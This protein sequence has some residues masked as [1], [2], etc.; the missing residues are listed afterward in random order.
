VVSVLVAALLKGDASLLIA[1]APP[2]AKMLCALPSRDWGTVVV[3]RP[4]SETLRRLEASRQTAEG[5]VLVAEGLLAVGTRQV[6]FGLPDGP[7]VV[8]AA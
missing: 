7:T 1:F 6:R 2:S 3:E 5:P 8:L 4:R